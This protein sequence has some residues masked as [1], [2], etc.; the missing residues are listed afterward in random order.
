MKIFSCPMCCN[1]NF[2]NRDELKNHLLKATTSL[3]CPACLKPFK[4]ILYLIKHLDQCNISNEIVKSDVRT[5]IH[6]LLIFSINK[7]DFSNLNFIFRK[8]YRKIFQ[9]MISIVK[10]Y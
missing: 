7:I 6:I 10:L 8:N 4:N 3:N 1:A 2:K 9:K 5:N